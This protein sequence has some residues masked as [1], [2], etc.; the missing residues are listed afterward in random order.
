METAHDHGLKRPRRLTARASC[1]GRGGRSPYASVRDDVRLSDSRTTPWSSRRLHFV[2]V[3]GCGMSGLALLAAAL[4]A[5][6]SGSDRSESRFQ[7]ALRARGI[8]VAIGHC[9]EHMPAGAELVYSTAIPVDNPER[10]IAAA[11]GQTQLRRGDLL[12]E[13]CRMRPCLAVAGTHGKTTT[14]AM[15]VCALTAADRQPS[16]AI[17]ALVL[18]TGLNADWNDGSWFVVE[19]DESD[20]SH[21]TVRPDVAVLTNADHDHVK[22]YPNLAAVRATFG[23]FLNG[24]PR[25]AIWDRPELL[26]L[27]SG[28]VAPFQATDVV[29][30]ASGTAFTWR[31][32][33]VRVPVLGVHNACNAAAALEACSLLGADLELAIDGLSRFGGTGRRLELR[34]TTAAGVLVYDDYAHHP[35]AVR[36]TLGALRAL[37]ARRIV[38]VLQP[39]G[40]P[41]VAALARDFGEALDAADEVVVVETVVGGSRVEDYPGVSTALIVRAACASRPGRPVHDIPALGAAGD[42]VRSTLRP[43]DVCVTLGCGDVHCVADHLLA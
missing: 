11:R 15:I 42:C 13:V 29:V 16:Y 21:L 14:S 12:A 27:R 38:A 43:G 4:A 18:D 22:R 30:G 33:R 7:T 39:W 35:T 26:A 19:T 41:R 1:S 20:G 25:A 5:D 32:R 28:P 23:A 24:V 2:G 10:A 8:P 3:N 34:G 37:G 9:H 31:G 40:L 17:G 6:V 36:A